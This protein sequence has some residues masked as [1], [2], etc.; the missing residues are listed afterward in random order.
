MYRYKYGGFPKL[1]DLN[2]SQWHKHMEVIL[3]AGDWFELTVR[4]ENALPITKEFSSPNTV[5]VKVKLWLKDLNPALRVP[6]STGKD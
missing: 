3:L 4:N 5:V 6:T 2:Y 1:N